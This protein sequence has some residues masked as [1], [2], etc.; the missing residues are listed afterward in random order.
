MFDHIYI[1]VYCMGKWCLKHSYFGGLV[2]PFIMACFIS[3]LCLLGER[4]FFIR[5]HPVFEIV[6]HFI[7]MSMNSMLNWAFH[8]WSWDDGDCMWC[9][10][11]P[12]N[13]LPGLS[14]YYSQISDCHSLRLMLVIWMDLT[15]YCWTSPAQYNKRHT[16]ARHKPIG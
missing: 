9:I 3:H 15:F 4:L 8:V 5:W 14:R 6:N 7:L 1:E 13:L 11:C 12:S 16:W 2:E 10:M